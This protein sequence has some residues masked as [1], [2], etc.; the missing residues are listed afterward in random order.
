MPGWNLK[1]GKL[2]SFDVSEDELW[3]LFNFVFSSRSKKRNTY[4]FGLIK[5]VLDNLF[6]GVWENNMYF[7]SYDEACC[8]NQRRCE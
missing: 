8:H 2:N 7:L 1:C 3:E 6:S 4:K 5:A